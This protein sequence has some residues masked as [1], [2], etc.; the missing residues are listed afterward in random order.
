MNQPKAEHENSRLEAL[1]YKLIPSQPLITS[2]LTKAHKLRAASVIPNILAFAKQYE[3]K[4][5]GL[6][7][8]MDGTRVQIRM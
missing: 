3:L 8:A 7:S 2:C 1:K 4:L 5:E 6:Q